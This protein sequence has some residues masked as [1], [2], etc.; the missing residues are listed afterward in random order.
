MTN[1]IRALRQERG[2]SMQDLAGKIGTSRSQIDK[3][4][5]GERRLTLEWMQRLAKGLGCNVNDIFAGSDQKSESPAL[6]PGAIPLPPQSL[7]KDLPVI[8]SARGGIHGFFFDNGRVNEY[9]V[10]AVNLTSVPNAFAVYVVGD[11]MEPR[12]FAGE[13]LYINPNRPL[14]K[15]CFVVVEMQDGQGLVKQFV[16]QDDQT[17]TLRQ[18]NPEKD[19]VLKKSDIKNVYRI[20]GSSEQI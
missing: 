15:D 14:S 3:L 4:E 19:I 20:V 6:M 16:R 7:Q 18:F 9:V 12:F 13:L 2:Y 5:K 11:A 8:G 17:I 1:R 10:R